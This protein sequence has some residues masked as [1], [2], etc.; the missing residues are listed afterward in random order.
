VIIIK[1]KTYPIQ[2]TEDRLEAIKLQAT[3]QGMTIK[4]FILV[5]IQE[6]MGGN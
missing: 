1:I 5:A 4:D 2:F 6:K 3:K